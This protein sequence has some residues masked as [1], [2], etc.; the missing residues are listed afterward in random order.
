MDTKILPLAGRCRCGDL[1]IEVDAAPLLTM[2]CHCTGCQRMTSSAFS[3]SAV[4]ASEAFA[5]TRGEPV[6][7]GLRESP[8]HYFCGFCMSWV[9]TRVE[10]LEGFVNVRPTMFDDHSWFSP[11]IETFTSER[12]PWART[13]AVHRFPRFPPDEAYEGLA[14]QFAARFDFRSAIGGPMTEYGR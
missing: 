10:G 1:Q 5:V 7:G 6:I 8:S 4:F 2:A 3:L 12:L 13:P 14:R 9:F 11:F